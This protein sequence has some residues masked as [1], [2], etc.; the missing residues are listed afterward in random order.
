MDKA[1]KLI[2]QAN[3]VKPELDAQFKMIAMTNGLKP[4]DFESRIKNPESIKSKID[5]HGKGYDLKDVNDVYGGRI[6]IDTP[7]QQDKVIGAIKEMGSNNQIKID[8]IEQVHHDTYHA[9]HVDFTKDGVKG[10]LQ[11]HTPGSLYESVANHA[12]RTVHGEKPP[13]EWEQVKQANQQRGY[14]ME[15]DKAQATAQQFEQVKKQ[16]GGIQ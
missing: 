10:E 6:V 12:I 5:K 15:P 4:E 14:K 3:K 16:M 9:V 13:A 11:I 2:A 7:N 8:K 1:S